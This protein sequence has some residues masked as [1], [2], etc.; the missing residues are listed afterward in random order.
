[1][2]LVIHDDGVGFEPGGIAPNS[3]GLGIMRERAE[4]IGAAL[5]IES[6]PGAGTQIEVVW[7]SRVQ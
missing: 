3:L 5:T 7:R 1:V 6:Q 4:A 2:E